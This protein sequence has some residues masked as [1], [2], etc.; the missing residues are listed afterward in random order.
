MQKQL[1]CSNHVKCLLIE[2][3]F[4]FLNRQ[5]FYQV[6]Q[7]PQY[8]GNH[9]STR[10]VPKV[11]PPILLCW[12]TISEVDVGDVTVEVEHSHQCCCHATDGSGGAV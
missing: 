2:F 4:L 11:W 7:F 3:S 10:D 6:H 5:I 12:L 1:H 8:T 9:L